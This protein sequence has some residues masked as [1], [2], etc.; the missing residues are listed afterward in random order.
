MFLKVDEDKKF[1]FITPCKN[2][3]GDTGSK[4]GSE[5]DEIRKMDS[6]K[7]IVMNFSQVKQIDSF[8]ISTLVSFN[9]EIKNSGKTIV[10]THVQP[11][12]MSIFKIMNIDKLFKFF[13]TEDDLIKNFSQ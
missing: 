9:Y 10:F 13:E 6:E 1:L 3:I 8:T 5:L 11:F 7:I 12:V 4:F 2:L